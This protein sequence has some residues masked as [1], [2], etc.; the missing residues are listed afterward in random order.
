MAITL[1]KADETGI[2]ELLQIEQSVVSKTYVPILD[3]ATWL[4]RISKGHAYFIRRD[5]ETVGS[6]SFDLFPD[7]VYLSSLVILPPYQNHGIGKE[8]LRQLFEILGADA[9]IE[10]VT[11]PD[12]KIALHLY[13]SLGFAVTSRNENFYGDGEPRLILSRSL[14]RLRP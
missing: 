14:A 11:H 9:Q 6:L 13:E 3:A 2:Q 4:E 5:G 8:A 1:E 10:L 7:H 12:N